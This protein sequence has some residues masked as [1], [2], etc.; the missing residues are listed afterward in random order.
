M[1]GRKK[2]SRNVVSAAHRNALVEAAYR[3]GFDGTGR[4]GVA[5]Y[6]AWVAMH[7]PDVYAT[8]ILARVLDL[9][10]GQSTD[11]PPRPTAAEN[12]AAIEAYFGLPRMPRTAGGGTADPD[13]DATDG[14]DPFGDLTDVDSVM[15]AAVAAP[16]QFCREWGAVFLTVPKHLKGEARRAWASSAN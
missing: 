15:L 4:D 5:G 2:G 11:P 6:F 9:E 1:G 10:L 8:E 12:N 7:H 14:A 16:K 3:I 13:R